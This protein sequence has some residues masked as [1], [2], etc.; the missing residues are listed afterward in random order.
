MKRIVI[1][2]ATSVI[3]HEAAKVFARQKAAFVI[4]GRDARKL[5]AVREDLLARGAESAEAIQADLTAVERHQE[6]IG[7]ALRQ[8]GQ[9]DG[10][11]IAYGMNGDQRSCERQAKQMLETFNTNATSLLALATLLANQLEQQKQG[12]LAVISS[13]AADRGKKSNYV[14]GSAKAGVEVFFQGLRHRFAGSQVR[15]L[16]IKPGYVKT[17]M[18][19]EQ[20]SRHPLAAHP[21]DVG[22]AIARAMQSRKGVIYLP[23]YWQPIMWVVKALPEAIFERLE[24]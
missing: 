24:L 16:T 10:A 17:P 2:G 11:L 1:F 6:L 20:L 22:R 4:I 5:A 19:S 18:L 14:Y 3:A 12:C 13:I 23:W 9:I 21:R 8:L 15:I 7:A